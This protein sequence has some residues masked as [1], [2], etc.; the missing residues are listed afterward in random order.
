ML[1]ANFERP[2]ILVDNGRSADVLYYHAFKQLCIKDDLLK[3]STTELYGV[4]EE[5]GKVTGSIELPVLVGNAPPQAV[6]MIDFLVVNTPSAYNAILGRPGH[7]LLRA[8]PFAYH[9]KMKFISLRGPSEVKGDQTRSRECYVTALKGKRLPEAMPIEMLDL[10]G[11]A[12][13]VV[14]EAETRQILHK[15]DTSGRLV[16]GSVE[17]SDFDIRYLPRLTIKA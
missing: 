13:V 16:R 2:K 6:A 3:P 4:A 7:N 9:Q 5:D 1:V 11:E 17:L 15:P 10:R 8:I 14:N 12:Q